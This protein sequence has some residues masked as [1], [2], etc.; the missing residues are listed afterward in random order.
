[1]R[2]RAAV[3]TVVVVLLAAIPLVLG[4]AAE[5]PGILR[6]RFVTPTYPAAPTLRIETPLDGDGVTTSIEF[7][8]EARAGSARTPVTDVQI[9]IDGG[10]WQSIPDVARG[11]PAAPFRV[12]ITLTPGDHVLE[13]RA[14]D[15]QVYSLVA[16]AH[17]R[18]GDPAPPTLQF[19]T[20]LDGA[21]SRSGDVLVQGTAEGA[22]IS[23]VV[24][25][26]REATFLA[27]DARGVL[28]SAN[29]ALGAGVQTIEARAFGAGGESVPRSITIS[30]GENHSAPMLT[31]LRP[32][33][34]EAFG[35]AGSEA[36]PDACVLFAGVAQGEAGLQGVRVS[37]DGA[38]ERWINATPSGGFA[39][40]ED[41][42][43]SWPL[44]TVPFFT[45]EHRASFVAIDK[46]GASSAPRN[47]TFHVR[48][49]KT[50]QIDGADAPPRPTFSPLSF[51]VRSQSISSVRWFLDGEPAGVLPRTTVLLTRPGDH[52]LT[53]EVSEPSGASARRQVALFALNQ[54]PVVA[55]VSGQAAHATDPLSLVATALDVDGDVRTYR[56]D[57]GDNSALSTTDPLTTH[58][59][60]KSGLYRVSVVAVDDW[61]EAS[62]PSSTTVFVSNHAP[63]AAFASGPE[64]ASMSDVVRFEDLSFD[65]DGL[66]VSRSWDFGDGSARVDGATV[67]HQ[68]R[69]RGTHSVVL[70]IADAEGGQATAE[71]TVFIRNLAPLASFNWTPESPEA[72]EDVFFR[73]TTQKSDGDLV[74]WRWD[75][76]DGTLDAGPRVHHTFAQPGT[77]TVQLIV[78]DDHGVAV[79]TVAR[80]VVSDAKPA[81]K[82]ILATPELPKAMDAV[83]FRAVAFDREGDLTGWLWDFGDKTNS[84]LEEPVHRYARSGIYNVT[85]SAT[86]SAGQTGILNITLNVLNSP[87]IA[88]LGRVDGGF[89]G[90]TTILKS[91][92]EDA[93]GRI[94][95]T[96]F[97]ADGDGVLDCHAGASQCAFI[98]PHAGVYR[99]IIQVIDDEGGYDESETQ[100]EIAPPPGSAAPPRVVVFSP[101]A[102]EVLRGSIQARGE[103]YGPRPIRSVEAQFRNATWTLSPSRG[104]WTPA[105][106]TDEWLLSINTRAIPDG[107]FD[108]VIRATDAEGIWSETRVPIVVSNEAVPVGVQLRVSNLEENAEISG[109][110]VVRG[111]AWHPAGVTGIRWRV[112]SGTWHQADGNNLAWSVPLDSRKLSPGAHLLQVDAY[113]GIAERTALSLPFRVLDQKPLLFVDSPPG[114]VA[115]GL[116][117][118]EGR[119][120][121][122]AMVLWRVDSDVWREAQGGASWTIHQDSSLWPGGPHTI[123]IKAVD[124]ESGVEGEELPFLVRFLNGR[125][126]ELDTRASSDIQ[127]DAPAWGFVGTLAALVVVAALRRK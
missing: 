58:R 56:W 78:K 15:G 1:M 74:A 27:S 125:V 79:P 28:W 64:N 94:V 95:T 127:R 44:S 113:H 37:V 3:V 112:D 88:Q 57:F 61:G 52:V 42:V 81:V 48:T 102:D 89:A 116:I 45:G 75:F 91:V 107:A 12:P 97:D 23:R 62:E 122:G 86:D 99:V 90:I 13:A 73:D 11:Y 69:S 98:Y 96:M 49:P 76:G 14:T 104:A 126:H 19:V 7:A 25:N 110:L 36:C 93:D 26:G 114:P 33:N 70:T 32:S 5:L 109:D 24:V 6:E 72:G 66:I 105:A 87:P 117:H 59:F 9:R 35:S 85:A 124:R 118:A 47:V 103:A 21:G 10:E 101:S 82:A 115:Y 108:L 4:G 17:V 119:A 43:W 121:P 54:K 123:R 65:P 67:E 46:M 29:L 120:S 18:A 38:P 20:P 30:L 16:R 77:Y 51:E 100:I 60:A 55:S 80:I 34:G 50:F 83:R 2:K 31:L 111:T 106:G 39:A 22:D 84:T 63:L 53:A 41:G 92:S 68:F 8:G 40:G 71:K